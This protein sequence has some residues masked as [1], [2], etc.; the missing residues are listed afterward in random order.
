MNHRLPSLLCAAAL[1]GASLS[2]VAYNDHRG[3][4]LDSLERAVARWTPDAVDRASEQELLNLNR[5]YRDLMLGYS[6]LNG[7]KC[8]FYAQRALAISL[9]RG[10]EEANADA[11]RYLGQH[12][13]GQE[14]YDSALV[15]YHLALDAVERIEGDQLALDDERS[16]LYGTLGN[17]Y[18]AQGNMPEAMEWYAKAGEIF[19]RYGWNESNSVLYYNIGEAWIEEGE[20][21]KAYE[22]YDK[23]LAYGHTAN[24]SLMVAAAQMGLGRVYIER[25]RPSKALRHLRAANEYFAAHEREQLTWRKETYE[26]ISAAQQ[27]QQHR[28]GLLCGMATGVLAIGLGFWFQRR[29]TRKQEAPAASASK[30]AAPAPDTSP[31]EREILDLLA[32]G[33]TTQQIAEAL[34]LSADTIKWYRRKLLDKFD[35]ANVA[36]LISSAKESGLV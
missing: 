4:N 35:V 32:K 36:E 14:Q 10:W 34:S 9:P 28:L 30:P 33:Y 21:K 18:N 29:R 12:F 1:L 13:Y 31:R 5:A 22:A 24:D 20:P 27:K 2:A 7:E 17:L 16:A 23:A 11:F 26:Y 25:G 15:Y 8:A 6:V 19:E 3:H